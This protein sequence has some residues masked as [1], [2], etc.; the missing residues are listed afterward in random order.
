[1][2]I[3]RE[4]ITTHKVWRVSNRVYKQ[5]PKF[6][7]DNEIGFLTLMYPSGY[8]PY[9]EQVNI[10]TIEMED[11]GESQKITDIDE[12]KAHLPK[13]LTALREARIRHGDLTRYAIVVRDNKPY[14]IDFAESR[15]WNDP[16]PDKRREGDEYWLTRT[17]HELCGPQ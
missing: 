9:A 14:I 16:R 15:W 1:M 4:Y 13:I 10:D 11:L 5:Q 6:L 7:T 8:V 3:I 12:F 17:M 2:N